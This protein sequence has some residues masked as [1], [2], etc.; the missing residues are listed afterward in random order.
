P[1]IRRQIDLFAE[2]YPDRLTIVRR[3]NRDGFKAGNLNGALRG[4]AATYEA[5][6]VVDADCVLQPDFVRRLVGHIDEDVHLA[7][8]QAA[9]EPRRDRQPFLADVMAPSMQIFWRDYMSYRNR[10]GFVPFLGRGALIR[11]TAWLTCGG[12]PE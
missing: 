6:A 4:P 7:F 10:F 12:F 2:L 3:P 11:R 8:V 5:F 1:D 9:C